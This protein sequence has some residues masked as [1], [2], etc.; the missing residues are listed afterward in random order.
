[1]VW[2]PDGS[3]AV[4]RVGDK[5]HL[6]DDQGKLVGEVGESG[7]GFAFSSDSKILYAVIVGARLPGEK[8]STIQE[9]WCDPTE[10]KR[11]DLGDEPTT[12][13]AEKATYLTAI[14]ADSVQHVVEVP[15]AFYM[16][17]S[18]NGAWLALVAP[19]HPAMQVIV[20]LIA[21]GQTYLISRTAGLPI[22]FTGDDR[23]AYVQL[24]SNGVTG[25]IVEL[26]LSSKD[27]PPARHPL[28]AVY[29]EET[30]F[31]QAVGEEALLFTAVDRKLPGPILDSGRVETF[32]KLFQYTRANSA[33][34]V[35]AESVGP[36][37]TL[38]PDGKHILYERI[39][40]ATETS[41]EKRELAVMNANGSDPH[42]LRDLSQYPK[43]PMWPAWRDA[44]HFSFVPPV[45]P[46][47]PARDVGKRLVY[48]VMLYRITG[49][50]EMDPEPVRVLSKDWPD[51]MRPYA[52][53]DLQPVPATAPMD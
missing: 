7:G 25:Q 14:T 5:A 12:S 31:F 28:L 32:P 40:P 13:S 24:D 45:T 18:P 4:W 53:H 9:D 10:I 39:T 29:A 27:V 26:T 6:M 46:E 2:S 36:L 22:A 15:P 34:A 33:V 41:E 47:H 44:E 43:L 19:G 37:F 3:K 48:D 11:S 16:T 50:G 1:M 30:T 20:H 35:V 52:T 42:S 23:L 17:A 8:L 21:T 49:E 38:S 51:D